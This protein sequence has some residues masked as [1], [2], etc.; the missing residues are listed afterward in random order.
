MAEYPF[1]LY[2]NDRYK[3]NIMQQSIIVSKFEVHIASSI[4]EIGGSPYSVILKQGHVAPT[5]FLWEQLITLG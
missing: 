1:A 4:S 5:I 3:S 2:V